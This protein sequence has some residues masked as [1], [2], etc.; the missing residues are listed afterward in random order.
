MQKKTILYIF[1][2]NRNEIFNIT[3]FI[4]PMF[5]GF[6]VLP[7]I[8][9][10]LDPDKYGILIIIWLFTNIVG[11]MDFGL[12]RALTIKISNKDNDSKHKDISQELF[13][14]C[15]ISILMTIISF[16]LKSLIIKTSSQ[17]SD[18]LEI[19]M[20]YYITC[21]SVPFII[22]TSGLRAILEG[23]EKFDIVNYLRVPMM[24]YNYL[25]PALVIILGYQNVFT[26]AT[27]LLIGRIVFLLL[28]YSFVA[29]NIQ[30]N[31]SHFRFNK[32][33]STFET[34]SRIKW[35]T[36]IAT[37]SPLIGSFDRWIVNSLTSAKE[38]GYYATPYEVVSRLGIIPSALV[39]VMIPTILSSKNLNKSKLSQ[40]IQ[41]LD[42]TIFIMLPI[43]SFFC[44]FSYEFLS[45]WINTDFANVS[46]LYLTIFSS[47]IFLNSLA[48]VPINYLMS[49]GSESTVAKNYIYQILIYPICLYIAVIQ[50]GTL[51]AAITWL[52]RIFIDIWIGFEKSQ[53]IKKF[54]V[55]KILFIVIMHALIIIFQTIYKSDYIFLKIIAYLCIITICILKFFKKE[56]QNEV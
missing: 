42:K 54:K 29:K 31:F 47:G 5:S 51:G 37:L 16:S 34:L 28:H 17:H 18:E 52:S 38:I 27:L 56:L 14:L 8:Q 13:V 25:L 36:L 45:H 20:S 11:L 32:I 26:I 9:R 46:Y 43:T 30:I 24:T 7:I 15:L 3:G 49:T 23:L 1:K 50:W 19:A 53:F 48:G 6:I 55:E 33:K 21:I 39:A 12:N 35:L 2:Q 4:L 41:Y 22:I 40:S 10:S 44:L